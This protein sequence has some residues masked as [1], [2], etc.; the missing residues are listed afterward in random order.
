MTTITKDGTGISQRTI[1]YAAVQMLKYAM[2][3]E[4]LARYGLTKPLPKNKGDLIKFR[5]QVPGKALKT[6]LVEGVTPNASPFRFEDVEVK[7]LQWG[8]WIPVTDVV[9]DIHEDPVLNEIAQNLGENVGR[10][11]E[12]ITW[13]KIRGGTSVFYANGASRAAVNTPIT[14]NLQRKIVKQLQAQKA[15]KFT[16]MLD[17][18]MKINTTPVEAAWIA[19]CHTDNEPDIRNMQGFRPTSEYASGS[20][21]PYELGR[22]ENVRYVCSPDLEGFGAV[23][24]A[25]GV[26]V[27][28]S[29]GTNA[30]VYPIIFLGMEAYGLVPLRASGG[31]SSGAGSFPP[32]QPFIK[33]PGKQES[34]DPLGQRGFASTKYWFNVL[35]LNER[36]MIR[37]EV[38]TSALN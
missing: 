25:P 1:G 27:V 36:W 4:V 30:D 29:N 7:I 9:M 24:G 35:I 14:L 31:D 18:S 32:V 3:V 15:M 12:Q 26:T 20:I 13:N 8:E 17:G 23:G 10:T 21:M 38:A 22:V 19:V 34:S 37:A 2:S 11:C 6:P 16:K 33:P 5:R 28:S